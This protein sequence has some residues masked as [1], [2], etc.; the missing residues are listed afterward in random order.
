M[1]TQKNHFIEVH[2]PAGLNYW[3]ERVRTRGTRQSSAAWASYE[4]E[5]DPK[6]LYSC[7]LRNCKKHLQS[8]IEWTAP[9][10]FSPHPVLEM[11]GMLRSSLLYPKQ[12][13]LCYHAGNELRKS[14]W[15]IKHASLCQSL[16]L[17]GGHGTPGSGP[18]VPW[19]S[20][21]TE[22]VEIIHLLGARRQ[23]QSFQE[24]QSY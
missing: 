3:A 24:L 5:L 13:T 22:K 9:W 8:W 6:Q 16:L 7:F 10:T 14:T 1:S 20:L 17:E 2:L 15:T 21:P 23:W 19:W 11:S 4:Q 12:K 18:E